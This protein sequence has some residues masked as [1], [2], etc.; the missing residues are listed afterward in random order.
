[1]VK[2]ENIQDVGHCQPLKWLCNAPAKSLLFGPQ[3]REIPFLS[4]PGLLLLVVFV[5]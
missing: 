4:S 2:V 1:M 5:S 3:G